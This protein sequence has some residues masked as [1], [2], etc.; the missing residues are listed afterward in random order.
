MIMRYLEANPNAA[1]TLDGVIMWWLGT[2]RSGF[3]NAEV[4]T[5]LEALVAD[6]RVRRT[7]PVGGESVYSLAATKSKHRSSD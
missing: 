7:T 2:N 5:A 4:L 3:S 1:D 6:G